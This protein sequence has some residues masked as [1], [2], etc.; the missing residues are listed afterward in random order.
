MNG[1]LA[2][3]DILAYYVASVATRILDWFHHKENK[4]WVQLETYVHKYPPI[5]GDWGT[6]YACNHPYITYNTSLS[7]HLLPHFLIMAIV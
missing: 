3:L 1:G 2:V 7:L 6:F 5:W 4:L